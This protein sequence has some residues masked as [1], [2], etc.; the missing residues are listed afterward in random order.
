MDD[1]KVSKNL[2]KKVQQL[3]MLGELKY[4]VN[5]FIQ[6]WLDLDNK[7]KEILKK[8][9]EQAKKDSIDIM[10][11]SVPGV[12]ALSARILA[13]ELGDMSHFYKALLR[14]ILV[15][16]A[17]RSIKQDR[18]LL[19]IFERISK[20]VG[21]KRA[22]VAIARKI[23]GC[24]RTCFKTGALWCANAPVSNEFLDTKAGAC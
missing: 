22:I 20:R 6:M 3:E 5:L 4:S 9:G 16:I 7:I 15:Q 19:E 24:I 12:G 21:K 13:N 14:M 11:R 8:L 18:R 10:Y 17:W 1:T 2:L 23:V